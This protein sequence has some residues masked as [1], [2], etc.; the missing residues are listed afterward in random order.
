MCTILA[1]SKT[2]KMHYHNKLSQDDICISQIKMHNL[3][4][5]VVEVVFNCKRF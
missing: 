3:V 1:A 4:L 2:M 5:Q